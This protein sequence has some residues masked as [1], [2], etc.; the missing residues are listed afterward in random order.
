MT[1]DIIINEIYLV[2]NFIVYEYFME[3]V[4]GNFLLLQKW[5]YKSSTGHT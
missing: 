5:N 2:F 3:C 4:D 1:V